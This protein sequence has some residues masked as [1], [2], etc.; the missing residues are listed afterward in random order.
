MPQEYAC[1]GR[2]GGQNIAAV[3][4]YSP[5]S[6]M[7]KQNEIEGSYVVLD[8]DRG[9]KV[10]EGTYQGTG[11]GCFNNV[12][13]QIRGSLKKYGITKLVT[14]AGGSG[15]MDDLSLVGFGDGE[16]SFLEGALLN[17]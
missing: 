6:K 13:D 14:F 5:N 8:A 12:L 1:F 7:I 3:V 16:I 9:G 10:E 17:S 2:D 15:I 4:L 11:K